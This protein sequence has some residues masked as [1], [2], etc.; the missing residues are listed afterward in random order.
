M[1]KSQNRRSYVSQGV[2]AVFAVVASRPIQ[3]LK[4]ENGLQDLIKRNEGLTANLVRD[5]LACAFGLQGTG[6]R[7]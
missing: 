6:L 7:V 3:Q 5:S 4:I 1:E 2:G